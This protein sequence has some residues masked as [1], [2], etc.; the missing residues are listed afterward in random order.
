MGK[1]EFYF[2]TKPFEEEENLEVSGTSD[3]LRH[4]LYHKFS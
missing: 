2:W 3:K 4:G 1:G